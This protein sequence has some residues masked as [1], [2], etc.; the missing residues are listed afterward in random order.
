MTLAGNFQ[1]GLRVLAEFEPSQR[2]THVSILYRLILEVMS[3]NDVIQIV[4]DRGLEVT[5]SFSMLYLPL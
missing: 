1:C 5:V 4:L 3:N 2:R